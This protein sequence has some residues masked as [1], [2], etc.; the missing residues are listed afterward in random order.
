MIEAMSA[1]VAVWL[2]W[3]LFRKHKPRPPPVQER[4]KPLAEPPAGE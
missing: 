4:K 1:L 3:V 2:T